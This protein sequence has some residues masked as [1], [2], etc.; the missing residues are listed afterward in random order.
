[1]AGYTFGK[2][3][4]SSFDETIQRTIEALAGEGFGVLSDIDVSATLQKKIGK[5]IPPYRILCACN[6]QFA[7][8]ALE[9]EPSIGALLPCNV[10]VRQDAGGAV[11]VEFMDPDSVLGL[12]GRPEVEPIAREVRGRLERVMTAL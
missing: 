4:S 3:V 5:S 12:V 11:R 2:T 7:S 10:V 8:Q 9:V 1:M 6:P